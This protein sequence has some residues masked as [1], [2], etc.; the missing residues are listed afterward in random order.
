[1][2]VLEDTEQKP[3]TLVFTHAAFPA[4]GSLQ[5]A[6]AT[7]WVWR[8]DPTT[9]QPAARTHTDGAVAG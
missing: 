3:S 2:R 4:W 7:G 1:M 9:P 6:T 8:Y 5:R